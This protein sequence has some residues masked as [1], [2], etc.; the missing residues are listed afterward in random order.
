MCKFF[1]CI[2]N[3]NGDVKFFTPENIM[4]ILSEKNTENYNF[5]SHAS[6]CRFYSILGQKEHLW[7]KWEYNPE[8][9][10]LK[11]DIRNVNNDELIVKYVLNVWFN[12]KDIVFL[13]NL[14]GRCDKQ[15]IDENKMSFM[16]VIDESQYSGNFY[17]SRERPLVRF[18]WRR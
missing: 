17:N 9:R 1:S 18:T 7:N 14:Y 10:Q 6:I 3:G 8:T 16:A 11:I 5:N 15:K 12:N 4:K 2:S 13:R